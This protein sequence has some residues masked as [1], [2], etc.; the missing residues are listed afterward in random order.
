M[1]LLRF[2]NENAGALN[3]VFAL[4]VAASTVFYAV[5][6]GKLVAETRRMRKAQTEPHVLVRAEPEFDR[7]DRVNIA[8]ENTGSGPAYNIK[9][10]LDKD[11]EW[12]P[13]YQVSGL[14]FVKNGLRLLAPRQILRYF[15]MP[16]PG[17]EGSPAEP[18]F[19]I[20]VEYQDAL[21]TTHS[22]EYPIDLSQFT[23]LTSPRGPLHDIVHSL[24]QLQT[25][26]GLIA[27]GDMCPRVITYPYAEWESKRKAAQDAR[28]GPAA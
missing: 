25:T 23:G 8:V 15:L 7:F 13:G 9:F 17:A 21:G 14:G 18:Y 3:V 16:S 5:L 1:E 28:K 2:L 26:V 12:A 20:A 4:I 19:T 6:T 11:F 10:S 24:V 22:S 27:N